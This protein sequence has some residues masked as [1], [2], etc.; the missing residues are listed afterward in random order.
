MALA[1]VIEAASGSAERALA[2]ERYAREWGISQTTARRHAGIRVRPSVGPPRP[3][4][5]PTEALEQA[6]AIW[7]SS[8]TEKYETATMPLADVIDLCEMN[9][10]WQAGQISRGQLQR[11]IRERHITLEDQRRGTP[12]IQQRSEHP[13]HVH[14]ADVTRCR[15]W[16]LRDDGHVDVQSYKR[17]TAEYRNK[18]LRGGVPLFRYV[19]VDHASGL[20]YVQYCTDETAAT[21]LTF[22]AGGWLP[23]RQRQAPGLHGPA[24]RWW[25]VPFEPDRYDEWAGLP[26][27]RDYY[28]RGAPRLLVV[29][30]A[31]QNQSEFTRELCRR[32]GI[33]LVIA[34]EARAKGAVE[35][36]MWIW[37][38][39][40]ETRLAT[41]P[42][43]DLT[44]LNVWALDFLAHWCRKAVH[45]RHGMTRSQAWA[46]IQPEQLREL[47][48]WP[49]FRELARR[50]PEPR[51][52]KSGEPGCGVIHHEGRVW[53]L[54]DA[55][56]IGQIVQVSYSV[57]SPATLEAR[58]VDG[59][60]FL[61]EAVERDRFGF[62]L[63]A[64]LIGQAHARHP[65]TPTQETQK[66]LEAV[67]TALPPLEVFGREGEKRD[68]P[69]LLPPRRGVEISV[70][71]DRGAREI[72]EGQFNRRVRAK[73]GRA[74]AEEE[75]AERD[76][77]FS[78]AATL[79]EAKVEE[80]IAWCLARVPIASPKIVS[81]SR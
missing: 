9:G 14:L 42:A 18:D 4:P 6:L 23:K 65:D 70:D 24:L 37:E 28:F 64:P 68:V 44:T 34:Q 66:R 48:A 47:P 33:E 80:F 54:A 46:L 40:F 78:A 35:T 10:I 55:S 73:L 58:A 61:L 53:R 81:V 15:Q 60:V 38:R 32:L 36:M 3:Y 52:V 63:R 5:V 49:I 59:R 69:S 1:N 12:W 26:E 45:S 74:L 13:N 75:G 72:T 62:S 79:P 20:P 43:T 71:L 21:L 8:A 16:Y 67:R 2:I 31:S 29:D 30:R 25:P 19:L 22:L 56:L 76:R 11:Y 51:L 7:L 41:Q 27:L 17:G 39:K 77:W 57:F 50:A